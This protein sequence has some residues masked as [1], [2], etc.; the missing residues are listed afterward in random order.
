M[1]KYFANM[2]VN[3]DT[4]YQKDLE[5]SNKN[6]LARSISN[7]ARAN[8]YVG[9]EYHWYVWDNQGIIVLAGAGIKTQSGNFNYLNCDDLIGT[10]I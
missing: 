10:P 6:K 8:C 5:G 3:S 2:R 1:S 9:N 7:S 4:R